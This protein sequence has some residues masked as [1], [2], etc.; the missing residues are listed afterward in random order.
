MSLS[1]TPPVGVLAGVYPLSVA[2]DPH[3]VLV[4]GSHGKGWVAD[5]AE[6]EGRVPAGILQHHFLSPGMLQEETS[7]V[8]HLSIKQEERTLTDILL[9]MIITN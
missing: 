6:G 2:Q 9:F 5:G 1:V 8:V 4:E 7:Y 3:Q